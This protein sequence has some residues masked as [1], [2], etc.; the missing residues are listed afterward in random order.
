MKL[1]KAPLMAAMVGVSILGL[2]VAA[3][4]EA[5][6]QSSIP[7]D[8][9]SLRNVVNAVQ[10]SPDGKHVL[11]H[12][13][14]TKDGEYLLQIFRTDDLS[15]PVRT[16]AA[17]P[18]EIISARWVSDNHI[19]GSAWQEVRKR[20]TRPEENHRS[21]KAYFYNLEE[22]KFS[23]VDGN[24]GIEGLLPNE[25]NHILIG[26]GNAIPD[27]SGVDPFAAFRPVSYYKFDLRSG[28]RKLVIKGNEKYSNLAFDID[29]N[30]R[31]AEGY[32]NETK[33]L[34]YYFR[35][36]GEG[37]WTQFGDEFDL[38]DHEN[39][40][41]VLGGFQG[42]V[43]FDDKDTN[44][45]YII[46]NRDGED[47]AALYKFDFTSGDFG[48]KMFQAEDSD[49]MGVQTHSI[50]GNNKLVA[51]MYPGAKR[52]RH[53][54]DEEEKALYEALE[55]QIPYAHQISITSRSRD[56]NTM[57]VQN[58][59][60]RDPGS[61]WMVK[62]GQMAKLGSRNPLIN[63]D[64]L[65][66]V[67]YIRYE[68][69]DGRMI[70]AYVTVPKG[71]GP[72][73][74]VVQHHGGP[75]VN[76]VQG[77][78]EIGQMLASAGYMVLYPQNRISTGWGKSHF[79]AGY[80]EHGLAMQDDKDDG[81]LYLIEQGLVDPDRVAFYGWSYGGYAALVASQREDNIYQCAIAMAGVSDPAKSYR[82]RRGTNSPK[83]L[84]D[85]GKRRGMIGVNPIEDVAKAN[86][87]LLMAHGD[88]D[89]RVR[90]Y[91]LKD[92]KSALEKAGKGSLGQFLT[93]KGV[94]HNNL[95]F[96]HQQQLYT[97]M[98]DFLANDCGPGGL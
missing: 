63:P 61:F 75:H 70:P 91:H 49:V 40:Y 84:D 34:S 33:K 67:K 37:S 27:S 78:N 19:F 73:P 72:F 53:W 95:M 3:P 31:Y 65:S 55:Q 13:N 14:P 51:A 85:W 76:A 25:P 68:A 30:P 88:V 82:N 47:K 74:L 97:K 11:V 59:G 38:D 77:Y 56:G 79:D 80:G 83:A 50:P 1:L 66:D 32:D 60:P 98:L 54:F 44:I 92:Y 12:I 89:S 64:Q 26:T 69:R 81:A 62:D 16:L 41:R 22:N 5:Q 46:D 42:L 4:S 93:L 86:I 10:V 29:G 17:D 39:L 96:D 15:E 90:Y 8:V 21:F 71:E 43:G 52:E 18:M 87:P 20:V 48:E 23:T 6:A 2:S 9:W 24:F 45:G 58:S 35:R 57:I 94:D 28:S 7:V 36:P